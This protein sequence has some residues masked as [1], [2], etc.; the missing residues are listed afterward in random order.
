MNTKVSNPYQNKK[1]VN[2]DIKELIEFLRED[3]GFLF[4]KGL[5]ENGDPLFGFVHQTFQ[6]YFTSIEFKT[7]WLEGRY[8]NNLEQYVFSPNWMEVIKLC[9]SS[10]KLTDH[11]LAR[12]NT[13]KFLNDILNVKDVFQ[14][15]HR[16]LRLVLNSLIEETEVDFNFFEDIINRIFQDIISVNQTYNPEHK[17]LNLKVTSQTQGLVFK[18]LNTKTYFSFLFQKIKDSIYNQDSSPTLKINLLDILLS[19]SNNQIVLNELIEIIKSDN[20]KLKE[21]IFTSN[22]SYPVPELVRTDEFRS[23]I[24][25][26]INN[27][28][29]INN[30]TTGYLPSFFTSFGS[31]KDSYL[32]W[33]FNSTLS[34]VKDEEFRGKILNCIRLIENEKVK[35]GYANSLVIQSSFNTSEDINEFLKYLKIEYPNFNFSKTEKYFDFILELTK[36]RIIPF[37]SIKYQDVKVFSGVYQSIIGVQKGSSLR[38]FSFPEEFN[39]IKKFIKNKTNSFLEFLYLVLPSITNIG[40]EL[41]IDNYQ[42]LKIFMCYSSSLSLSQKFDSKISNAV[43]YAVSLVCDSNFPFKENIMNWL[44]P[45][46]EM[47]EYFELQF[48]EKNNTELIE[49][50]KRSELEIYEKMYLL[51][52]V[53]KQSDFTPYIR[54][55]IEIMNQVTPEEK[56][57]IKELLYFVIE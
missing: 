14:E 39:D 42:D 49:K 31:E 44:K 28:N 6:E 15:K 4:E 27:E 17:N 20:D 19:I 9:A 16:P 47:F 36:E 32:G 50:V 37:P 40:T 35:L 11:R 56:S 8:E 38:T 54:P 41:L 57:N 22:N 30:Y 3:A 7:R 21:Y 29:Y 46:A 34:F 43:I 23:A 55:T 2:K 52:I 10:F 24:L 18:L 45:S 1:E 51:Y 48:I 12:K 33:F 26:Y 25:E 53:G 13:T 5:N